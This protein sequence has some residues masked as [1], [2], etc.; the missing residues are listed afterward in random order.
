MR[1]EA[2]LNKLGQSPLFFALAGFALAQGGDNP[3][4]IFLFSVGAVISFIF[5][6]SVAKDIYY[7]DNTEKV[8]KR[9]ASHLGIDEAVGEVVLGM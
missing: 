1:D 3:V 9:I 7:R 2:V 5:A 6:I 8:M 4:K